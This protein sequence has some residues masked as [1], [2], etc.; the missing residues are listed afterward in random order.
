MSTDVIIKAANVHKTYEG[1][2][3]KVHAL[4]GV[5]LTLKK[6]EMVAIMGPS[7]CGKTT[8]LNCLSGLDDVTSGNVEIEGKSLTEMSENK[9]TEYRAQHM[10][11]IFQFYNLLPVL[12]AL[13]NVELP[14]LI[15]RM[16]PKEA[17]KKAMAALEK[18]GLKGWETHKPAEL[19][20]GQR[21]RV[22]IARSLVNDP[23]IVFGDEPTGD[24]DRET[25]E[26]ILDIICELNK[27]KKQ[28]FILVTHD[29][30]VAERTHRILEMESGV[31]EREYKPSTR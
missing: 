19:S 12:T 6:G 5:D 4:R 2:N 25:T 26:G 13:E 22:T 21:Q 15:S 1:G 16:N 23:Y 3:I 9:K 24:L 7:G 29:P 28:T 11:F 18:V 8:L 10:G 31:I 27:K 14:L 30:K 17:Q 20:G